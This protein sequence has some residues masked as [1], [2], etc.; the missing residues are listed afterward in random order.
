METT[1]AASEGLAD[2]ILT[3]SFVKKGPALRRR[4]G[5]IKAGEKYFPGSLICLNGRTRIPVPAQQQQ[6]LSLPPTRLVVVSTEALRI[7]VKILSKISSSMPP[8]SPYV[9]VYLQSVLSVNSD[10]GGSS[11]RKELKRLLLESNAA[12][13]VILFNEV[14]SIFKGLSHS[15]S[16][17]EQQ[18]WMKESVSDY[19]Q[20]IF[21]NTCNF[22]A[23]NS[24]SQIQLVVLCASEHDSIISSKIFDHALENN[25]NRNGMVSTIS[26][27]TQQNVPHLSE[28]VAAELALLRQEG[29][30]IAFKHYRPH[31]LRNSLSD[32]SNNIFIGKLICY[33]HTCWEGEVELQS[34]AVRTV[35][36]QGRENMNRALD[37]DIVAIEIITAASD[38]EVSENI[39]SSSSRLTDDAAVSADDDDDSS[40]DIIKKKKQLQTAPAPTLNSILFRNISIGRVVGIIQRAVTDI[41]VT[42]P[43]ADKDKSSSVEPA[44]DAASVPGKEAFVLVTPIARN[45]PHCRLRTRLHQKLQGQ[46][47]IVR[48]DNWPHDSKFPNVHFIRTIG[49][50]NDWRTD[51]DALLERHHIVPRPF[52]ANALRCLPAIADSQLLEHDF[53]GWRH[54]YRVSEQWT[55]SHWKIPTDDVATK[56]SVTPQRSLCSCYQELVDSASLRTQRLDIRQARRVFS[57]DPVGCQD[58]DDA[59]CVSWIDGGA[60]SHYS[61]KSSSATSGQMEV[62]VMIADVCAFVKKGTALDMEAQS[63]GTTVYLPH[64]RFDMLPKL[65][66][67][68]IASLHG[69]KDRFAVAVS[70]LVTVTHKDGSPVLPT[71]DPVELHARDDIVFT[72]PEGAASFMGQVAI[73][74]VAAMTY[75]QAHSLVHRGKLD[76]S[77]GRTVP[78]GQAGRPVDKSLWQPLTADLKL[79]TVFGRFLRQRRIE[80]G[81]IMFDQSSATQLRF[82]VNGDSGAVLGM[83]GNDHLEIHSTIEELMILANSAVA[84]T[85]TYADPQTALIRMHPPA[86]RTHM[87]DSLHLL[88]ALTEQKIGDEDVELALKDVR[89]F[90]AKKRLRIP[91]QLEA[92]K[93]HHP[94]AAGESREDAVVH[95]MSSVMIRSMNEAKYVCAGLLSGK[96]F[97]DSHSYKSS[98]GVGNSAVVSDEKAESTVVA[99]SQTMTLAGHS[100]LGLLHYTHF[101]S[102]IRRYADVVVHRQLLAL[103][104]QT[105]WDCRNGQL[106]PWVLASGTHSRADRSTSMTNEKLNSATLQSTNNA[107]SALSSSG[108]RLPESSIRSVQSLASGDATQVPSSQS[109]SVAQAEMDDLLFASDLRGNSVVNERQPTTLDDDIDNLLAGVTTS[110]SNSGSGEAVNDDIDDLLASGGSGS[111]PAVGIDDDIDALLQG[112]DQTAHID[113][114]TV[115]KVAANLDDAIDDL[116]LSV[117]ETTISASSLDDDIDALLG[118]VETN[119]RSSADNQST[120]GSKAAEIT[121]EQSVDGD[122]K[123]MRKGWSTPGTVGGSENQ[124]VDSYSSTQVLAITEHLNSMTR[125]SKRVQSECQAL[126]LTLYYRNRVE[127]HNGVICGLRANGLLIYIPQLDFKGD[128]YLQDNAGIVCLDPA[129]LGERIDTGPEAPVQFRGSS[130]RRLGAVRMLPEYECELTEVKE[131]NSSKAET[132]TGKD[133]K[134]QE[135]LVVKKKTDHGAGKDSHCLRFSLLQNIRVEVSAPAHDVQFRLRRIQLSLVSTDMDSVAAPPRIRQTEDSHSR[136]S[137]ENLAPS[138]APIAPK[139]QDTGSFTETGASFSSLLQKGPKKWCVPCS[140]SLPSRGVQVPGRPL[141]VTSRPAVVAVPVISEKIKDKTAKLHLKLTKE[142]Q[143]TRFC[144]PHS[145]R[146]AFG[147]RDE[148]KPIFVLQRT[149]A[150][151]QW[152]SSSSTQTN[153]SVTGSSKAANVNSRMTSTISGA[154]AGGAQSVGTIGGGIDAAKARMAAWGETW[155][156]EE[157]LPSSSYGADD[158]YNSSSSSSSSSSSAAGGSSSNGGP[159]SGELRRQVQLANARMDKLKVAK[160]RSKYD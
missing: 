138:N 52:S 31:L 99:D 70:W 120:E 100:G 76:D 94:E 152:N 121:A 97:A 88:N 63:R 79:L 95:L 129:L 50:P 36:I 151:Q 2:P 68:D 60:D 24:R 51:I 74:S 62:C 54:K 141:V 57:V 23:A 117:G 42:V 77:D 132:A 105:Y 144:V 85:L 137:K 80:M 17:R 131:A 67:S 146:I 157:E 86:S 43:L 35:V 66:S 18:Y 150:S 8:E 106:P 101:T 16:R 55:D 154:A 139:P 84:A 47:V 64:V 27:F 45:I 123:H 102:P 4:C 107:D 1:A 96:L 91:L 110:G 134:T 108:I 90:L 28:F 3:L 156:E 14:Q 147:D 127:V 159:M 11:F 89:G 87:G 126:F 124:Q 119:S 22:L 34:A 149:L 10:V 112:S 7:G 12:N 92:G 48:L 98:S 145:G 136:D 9:F 125:R 29:S 153:T 40:L 56:I 104:V 58:I 69:N 78:E 158:N 21:V 160:R 33:E 115:P 82:D 113:A 122:E 75:Y 72:L 37:G 109:T 73:R 61:A 140:F 65:L 59:M 20:R 49:D 143:T 39:W 32:G 15:E 6:Q 53:S 128:L 118:S 41:V 142:T 116:L 111:I 133:A 83:H 148:M 114:V 5:Q 30:D 25:S 19:Q 130:Q 71:E 46:R 38:D 44:D 93:S 135:Q 103:F 81:A 13:N 26:D 155:A